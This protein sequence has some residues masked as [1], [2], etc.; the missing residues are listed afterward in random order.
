MPVFLAKFGKYA[1]AVSG[2]A[3]QDL[4][5]ACAI[6]TKKRVTVRS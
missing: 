5:A 2:M 4:A 6:M 1:R 3:A